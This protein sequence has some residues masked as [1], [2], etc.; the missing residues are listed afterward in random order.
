MTTE[1]GVGAATLDDI[2]QEVANLTDLFRRRLLDDKAKN[3]LYDALQE[4]AKTSQDLLRYRA[5]ESLFREA[6][7]AIDRLQSEATTPELVESAVEELLEVFARRSLL[8]VDDSGEFDPRVH[9]AVESIPESDQ[10]PA[11][12]IVAVHRAGYTLDGRLLRPAQ[13]TVAVAT[14][15]T[16]QDPVAQEPDADAT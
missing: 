3:S 5:F 16:P 12:S 11:G 14:S 13:V 10:T 9:E 1:G 4:Q 15:S 2:R 7:L 8:P 6:L